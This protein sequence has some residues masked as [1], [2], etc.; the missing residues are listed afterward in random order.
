MDEKLK[1]EEEYIENSTDT[2]IEEASDEIYSDEGLESI[3]E[4]EEKEKRSEDRVVRVSQDDQKQRRSYF[5]KKV[6]KLCMKKIDHV[7][8]KDT[9]F[10]KR[11]VTDRGKI[12]PRRITGTCAKHQRV[13][14]RAIK[15]ARMAALLPF[16]AK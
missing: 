9:D 8:Y 1:K 3:E 10:L 7:D 12:L 4:S 11:F 5:K 14:S 16:V 15:R 6:C 13:L 2:E